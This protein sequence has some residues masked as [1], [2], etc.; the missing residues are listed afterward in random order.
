M[1]AQ[2]TWGK[3]FQTD[4]L[5]ALSYVQSMHVPPERVRPVI[6]GVHPSGSFSTG[7][8]PEAFVGQVAEILVASRRVFVWED[9]VVYQTHDGGACLL[10]AL[11][12]RSRTEPHTADHLANLMS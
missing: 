7:M 11:A 5:A 2:T 4:L 8:T 10:V 9:T 3:L 12:A 1:T 6:W